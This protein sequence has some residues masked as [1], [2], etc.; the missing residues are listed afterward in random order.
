MAVRQQDAN[1]VT[2]ALFEQILKL[3]KWSDLVQWSAEPALLTV[4]GFGKHR[5]NASMRRPAT[6]WSG[7]PTD[8]TTSEIPQR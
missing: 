2:S 5:G 1:I 6:I 3:A 8:R 7:S 4:L